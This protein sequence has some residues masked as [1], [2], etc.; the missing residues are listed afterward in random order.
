MDFHAQSVEEQTMTPEETEHVAS[1]SCQE[2]S[3]TALASNYLLDAA[4]MR[5]QTL[6]R[7]P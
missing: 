3:A 5:S 6:T 1:D 7:I 4:F 2:I